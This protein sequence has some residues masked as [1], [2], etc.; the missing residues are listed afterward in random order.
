MA[1]LRG[2][3]GLAEFAAD[4]LADPAARALLARVTVGVDAAREAAYPATW[5]AGVSVQLRDG[6][7]LD[8]AQDR[9]K[10]DPENPLSPQELEAKFRQLAAYGG[11]DGAG[12]ERLLDWL[13]TLPTAAHLDGAPLQAAAR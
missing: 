7:R 10:G 3:V 5:S 2:R 4:A 13:R 12:I 11:L 9:P 1:L 6:R 8:A